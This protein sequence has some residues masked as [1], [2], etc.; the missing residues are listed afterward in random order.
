VGD[1][2]LESCYVCTWGRVE[3]EKE[4]GKEIKFLK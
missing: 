1:G 3:A 4:E 2:F